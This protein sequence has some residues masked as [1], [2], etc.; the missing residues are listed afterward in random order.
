VDAVACE[1]LQV[2][3]WFMFYRG[4]ACKLQEFSASSKRFHLIE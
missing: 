1:L 4:K 3:P 2:L